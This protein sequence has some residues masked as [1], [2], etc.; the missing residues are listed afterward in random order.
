MVYSC[1][2]PKGKIIWVIH[3]KNNNNKKEMKK[4][5]DFV[6]HLRPLCSFLSIFWR[7]NRALCP[8][9]RKR[10][11]TMSVRRFAWFAHGIVLLSMHAHFKSNFQVFCCAQK[12][13]TFNIIRESF[14]MVNWTEPFYLCRVERVFM[15]IR[16]IIVCR[17]WCRF[18]QL[19]RHNNTKLFDEFVSRI[20]CSTCR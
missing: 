3:S 6:Q 5:L 13:H 2:M 4:Q 8:F 15:R 14:N 16:H 19:N 11:L 9:V 10:Q 12:G 7:P 20:F 1:P 17:V 18:V